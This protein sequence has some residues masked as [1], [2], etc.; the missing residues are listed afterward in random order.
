MSLIL[1]NAYMKIKIDD[2][3]KE[4]ATTRRD[5]YTALEVINKQEQ[6]IKILT[7][8]INKLELEGRKWEI[9]E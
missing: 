7:D 3:A 4:L 6:E 5:K 9:S 1:D 2:L 8:T